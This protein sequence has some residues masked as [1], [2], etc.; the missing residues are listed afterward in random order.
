M[1]TSRVASPPSSK[2]RLGAPAVGPAQH[3]LGTPPVLLQGLALPGIDRHPLGVIGRATGAHGHRGGGRIL[4]GEDVARG[5]AH[6]GAQGGEG[7]DEHRGLHGH[8]ERAGDAGPGQGLAVEVLGPQG[9]QAGHLVLG[10]ADL[11]AA[12]LSQGQVGH[13]EI[14]LKGHRDPPLLLRFP[15]GISRLNLWSASVGAVIGR[16]RTAPVGRPPQPAPGQDRGPPRRPSPR[17]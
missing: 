2:M 3:L 11:L 7:L 4:G 16:D 10:Q 17:R 5:P 13:F 1:W 8:V 14:V 9:H 15:G 6:L 12:G